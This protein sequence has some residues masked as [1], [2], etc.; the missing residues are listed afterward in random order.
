MLNNIIPLVSFPKS[1]NTFVRLVLGTV[2]YGTQGFNVKNINQFMPPS[3]KRCLQ[4]RLFY[5]QKVFPKVHA[6]RKQIPLRLQ[7]YVYLIR[8]PIHAIQS[9]HLFYNA[10]HNRNTSL[11]S[12][13]YLSPRLGSLVVSCRFMEKV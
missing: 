12:F 8:N 6:N 2:L 5:G 9:Y 13:E 7:K 11:A 3:F 10:R 4:E 1:G